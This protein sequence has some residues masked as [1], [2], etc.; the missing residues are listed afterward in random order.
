MIIHQFELPKYKW[1]IT[2]FIVDEVIYP[3][4]ILQAL[5]DIDYNDSETVVD[6]FIKAGVNAGFTVSVPETRS[7]VMMIGTAECAEEFQNT[8]DHEKGHLA[9]HIALENQIPF[10]S[11]DFTYLLGDIGKCLFKVCEP[12]LCEHCRKS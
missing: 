8:L 11:E 12:F 2:A 6:R 1:N 10:V 5:D 7:S 3:D 9:V 4:I